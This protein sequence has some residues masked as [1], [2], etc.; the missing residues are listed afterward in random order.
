MGNRASNRLQR[1]SAARSNSASNAAF[2]R[3]TLA[4]LPAKFHFGDEMVESHRS[5]RRESFPA[6]SNVA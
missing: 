6:P 1:D 5:K 2:R 4:A 3:T